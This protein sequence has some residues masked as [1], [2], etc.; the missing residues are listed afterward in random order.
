MEI[1]FWILNHIDWSTLPFTPSADLS[2]QWVHSFREPL[3]QAFT[4]LFLGS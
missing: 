4:G 2:I 1:T 3:S